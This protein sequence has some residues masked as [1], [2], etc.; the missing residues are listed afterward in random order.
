[1]G[2]GLWFQNGGQ[3]LLMINFTHLLGL[4][5]VVIVFFLLFWKMCNNILLLLIDSFC[6]YTRKPSQSKSFTCLVTLFYENFNTIYSLTTTGRVEKIWNILLAINVCCHVC[7]NYF[8]AR[9]TFRLDYVCFTILGMIWFLPL[10]FSGNGA[11]WRITNM[12]DALYVEDVKCRSWN[13]GTSG[14]N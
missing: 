3:F 12:A 1:M 6:T 5:L 8:M 9:M 2:C 10:L 14:G 4:C 7:Y 11:G 13:H